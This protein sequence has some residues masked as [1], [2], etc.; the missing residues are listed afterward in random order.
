MQFFSIPREAVAAF[1]AWPSLR[2]QRGR[3]AS[4]ISNAGH[5]DDALEEICIA[6]VVDIEKHR[7]LGRRS[8]S[9]SS[10]PEV[11]ARG[12]RNGLRRN[13]RVMSEAGPR[14]GMAILT[15]AWGKSVC[16]AVCRVDSLPFRRG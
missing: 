13:F 3:R 10:R 15:S 6:V 16:F 2:R 12:V 4:G 8:R 1:R 5:A 9:N 14:S 11:T 7:L